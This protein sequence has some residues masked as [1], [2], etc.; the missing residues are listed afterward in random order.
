MNQGAKLQ[1]PLGSES[2]EEEL[3]CL[4]VGVLLF[5]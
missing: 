2:C 3:V 5:A 1:V 4:H